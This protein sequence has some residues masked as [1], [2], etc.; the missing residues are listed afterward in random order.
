MNLI[1]PFDG[2][3]MTGQIN[4]TFPLVHTVLN[5]FDSKALHCSQIKKLNA[6]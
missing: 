1:Q 6:L 4:N 3:N 5:L 2:L